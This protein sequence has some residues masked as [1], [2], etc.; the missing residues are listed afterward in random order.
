MNLSITQ[1][2]CIA[3][4]FVGTLAYIMCYILTQK[5]EN[6]TRYNIFRSVLGAFYIKL[7][8]LQVHMNTSPNPN[9]TTTMALH[10]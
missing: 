2:Y 9:F 3:L 7:K 1:L 6:F 8:L 10:F 5:S 4:L